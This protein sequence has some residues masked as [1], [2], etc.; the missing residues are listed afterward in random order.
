MDAKAFVTKR[1]DSIARQLE[2][3]ERGYTP[4]VP[5]FGGFGGG[6][7]GRRSAAAPITDAQ[8]RDSVQVP[9]EFAA[10]LFARSPAVNYPVAISA[11]PTGAIYVASD[12]QGSLG[13]D[14]NGGKV[15]RCVDEDG[16]GVMDKV[17]TFCKVDH[18]RGV[19]YRAGAVWVSHP[20]FLSVFHDDDGDGVADRHQQLVSGL[21][22]EL[23]NTRGG[24]HTTNGVRMGIDGW[25]YIGDGD[26]GVPK[27]VGLDGQTVVLRGG[28][29]LRVPPTARNWNCLHRVFAIRSTLRSTRS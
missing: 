14:P 12:E 21:T 16:D 10:T 3:I 4:R 6:G 27:A 7:S 17:T 19:V 1:N 15:L 2:G 29:I 9:D 28:G 26:Y 8:F 18:V 13:T 23:V 5:N 22:S 25:L 20:P 11:E 24:D